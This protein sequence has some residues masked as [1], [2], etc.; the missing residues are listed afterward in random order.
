MVSITSETGSNLQS[1]LKTRDLEHLWDFLTTLA[2]FSL[3]T[4]SLWD[5]KME[6]L[7]ESLIAGKILKAVEEIRNHK[8]SFSHSMIEHLHLAGN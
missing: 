7:M 2:L 1:S 3:R 6:F 5:F 8:I 4:L